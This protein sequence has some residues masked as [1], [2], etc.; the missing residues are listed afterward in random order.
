MGIAR[1]EEKAVDGYEFAWTMYV[2]GSIGCGVA[3][4]LLVRRWGRVWSHFFL[5]TVLALLLTPYALDAE[6]MTMAPA[7]FI[8]VFGLLQDGIDAVMPV[9]TVLLGVWLVGLV[10]SLL[11]Q[12]FTRNSSAK[13]K[14]DVDHQLVT[15][16]PPEPPVVDR[17]M[18][19]GHKR[20]API[21]AIR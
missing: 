13:V 10:I 12:F 19:V 6:A 9:I 2:L 15:E 16:T 17:K 5:V 21:R 7:L 11:V 3:A 14:A 20:E 8:I 1:I 18:N 4:W